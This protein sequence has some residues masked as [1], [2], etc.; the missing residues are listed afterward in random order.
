MKGFNMNETA[1]KRMIDARGIL[2]LQDSFFGILSYKLDIIENTNIPTCATD[3]KR[4][5]YNPDFVN[6]LR[7]N[8][9][10]GVFAHEVMHNMMGHG[11]RKNNREHKKWNV[12]CDYAINPI[13]IDCGFVL[14]KDC[15]SDSQY[16]NKSAEEIYQVIP[17]EDEESKSG[18]SGIGSDPGGCGECIEPESMGDAA[19]L[20]ADWK[21][22]MSS[23]AESTK[24]KG[25]MP[26][27]LERLVNSIINPEIPWHILLRDFVEL[28]AR[29][30]YDWRRCNKRYLP[31]GVIMPS[32]ISEELPEVVIAID[33]S[34]SIDID[35]LSKF[36]KEASEVLESYN[37][38]IHVVYCDSQIQGSETY[39]RTDLPLT[40]NPKGGGGTRFQPVFNWVE[41][42]DITPSCLIYFTDMYGCFPE[43]EPYYPVLW[44]AT[45]NIKAPFGQTVKFNS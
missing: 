7:M 30:D 10:V 5:L 12:A 19:E 20:E 8:E 41:K 4:L 37:T 21:V 43:Q 33:T 23:A 27:S 2:V 29:N 34:G 11:W 39:S 42:K 25:S 9:L 28:S 35:T 17:D 38:T 31:N 15:L 14:P 13:L 44:L 16:K 22:A 32:M 40:L 3:G 26:E 6:S 18:G 36:A 24:R 1:K 45:S